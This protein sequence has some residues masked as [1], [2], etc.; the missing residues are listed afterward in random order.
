MDRLSAAQQ[1]NLES[2]SQLEAMQHK[3]SALQAR[4]HTEQHEWEREKQQLQQK[5]TVIEQREAGLLQQ[6]QVAKAENLAAMN[7]AEQQNA[8]ITDLRCRV[9]ELMPVQAAASSHEQKLQELENAHRVDLAQLRQQLTTAECEISELRNQKRGQQVEIAHDQPPVSSQAEALSM[10]LAVVSS[11]LQTTRAELMDRNHEVALLAAARDRAEAAEAA[12]AAADVAAT[13][14]GYAQCSI[15]WDTTVDVLAGQIAGAAAAGV[16]AATSTSTIDRQHATPSH[17]GK[18]DQAE[19]SRFEQELQIALGEALAGTDQQLAE[20]TLR[21]EAAEAQNEIASLCSM[22]AGG[23]A[24]EALWQT[25]STVFVATSEAETVGAQTDLELRGSVSSVLQTTGEVSNEIALLA[26]MIAGGAAAEAQRQSHSFVPEMQTRRGVPDVLQTTGEASNEIA[27]VAATIVGGAAAE[28]Q[29]HSHRTMPTSMLEAEPAGA[30]GDSGSWREISAAS[31]QSQPTGSTAADIDSI[32]EVVAAGA[33]QLARE[34]AAFEHPLHPAETSDNADTVA[35]NADTVEIFTAQIAGA[36]AQ[37]ALRICHSAPTE[38]LAIT[39]LSDEVA[40]LATQISGAAETAA[41][42]LVNQQLL[43]NKE[44]EAIQAELTDAKN[45]STRAE[46]Q[47]AEAVKASDMIQLGMESLVARKEELEENLSKSLPLV[48]ELEMQLQDH[49]TTIDELRTD[50]AS[51]H[52]AAETSDNA[53]TV[54]DNADTVEIFTAQIAGAAAQTALRIC[55]SAPTERLAITPLSDEVAG[56]ATQI[57]GAA[58]TAAQQ[59]VNQQLL[60]NKELEAIQAELTDAKNAS[61]R[62]E[63]Q[64]AEAVKASDMIQLGMESLVARK[65]ELEENLSKSLPLVRELEMQLQD[66]NTTI[67][68]LRTDLA[69]AHKAA[70]ASNAVQPATFDQANSNGAVEAEV[71]E[72]TAKARQAELD[73]LEDENTALRAEVV[74]LAS[75]VEQVEDELEA[76]VVTRAEIGQQLQELEQELDEADRTAEAKEQLVQELRR[77]LTV[78]TQAKPVQH[79]AARLQAVNER[80]EHS[81]RVVT[82][83]LVLQNSGPRFDAIVPTSHSGAELELA[84]V[85]DELLQVTSQI[86]SLTEKFGSPLLDST[87]QEDTTTHTPGTITGWDWQPAL[88]HL[89]DLLLGKDQVQEK[90][91]SSDQGSSN[92]VVLNGEHE[93]PEGKT[94]RTAVLKEQKSVLQKRANRAFSSPP[95]IPSP[96]KTH[97]AKLS[98]ET[99]MALNALIAGR[100][101]E[102]LHLA[103]TAAELANQ[104]AAAEIESADAEKKAQHAMVAASSAKDKASELQVELSAE[105]EAVV[106]LTAALSSTADEL[107]ATLHRNKLLEEQFSDAVAAPTP[108]RSPTEEEPAHSNVTAQRGSDEDTGVAAQAE[109]SGLS[110]LTR[111]VISLHEQIGG[112]AASVFQTGPN[113][114]VPPWDMA[115]EALRD[116]VL[117]MHRPE[118]DELHNARETLPLVERSLDGTHA[119]LEPSESTIY[120]SDEEGL[121]SSVIG[122][123]SDDVEDAPAADGPAARYEPHGSFHIV[124][125]ND[126]AATSSSGASA[127][128]SMQLNPQS[129]WV[130]Y[131][132]DIGDAYYYNTET[133][134]TTWD[135]P[136]EGVSHFY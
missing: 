73:K 31:M 62:A 63:M 68:E 75:E 47:A 9:Q 107:E 93:C 49:N 133:E 16:A 118:V 126:S 32:V 132:D 11:E 6:L 39:P 56:L 66:H 95:T 102:G 36:A 77:Q 86:R 128:S 4:Q 89:H 51:A 33:A 30:Q 79:A 80:L 116:R 119:V 15:E 123:S 67:D 2:N 12:A 52:K 131:S 84:T 82:E 54:A 17:N 72:L 134:E 44:L 48:R 18:C 90:H 20:Q 115:W 22:I 109:S 98:T 88:L 124:D 60:H 92:A 1:Q 129:P 112:P 42:Q 50:L 120:P 83:Q 55:H 58:E 27:L 100:M 113:D 125:R 87:R 28:A 106:E 71:E 45:A 76:A 5:M 59:L 57:S 46:M 24:A 81:V 8:K 38:R 111:H 70:A 29:R 78:Q 94:Q 13:V 41:Q 130:E 103:A 91:R 117:A 10:S 19:D 23:A 122:P 135:A 43:H 40:G 53:D 21:L 25:T 114:A 34:T 3:L 35:D 26:A 127:L 105:K 74:R 108:Q 97:A 96:R 101:T 104:L 110:L 7:R 136:A 14:N 99:S 121:S 61:T 37:T 64:A 65:E 85:Q 69:S